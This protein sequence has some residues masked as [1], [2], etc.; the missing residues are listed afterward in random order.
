MEATKKFVLVPE[1]IWKRTKP[2]TT[3]HKEKDKPYKPIKPS[4]PTRHKINKQLNK[5]DASGNKTLTSTIVNYQ[6]EEATQPIKKDS[7]SILDTLKSEKLINFNK[8]NR[9][10]DS[11]GVTYSSV[12]KDYFCNFLD[13]Q[14]LFEYKKLGR[15]SSK[16]KNQL[17]AALVKSSI[18]PEDIPNLSVR[19]TV[20]S[21]RD[22][23]SVKTKWQSS[24]L[25]TVKRQTRQKSP[26]EPVWLAM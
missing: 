1:S 15:G 17:V 19:D 6:I 5:R 10:I 22:K 12:S 13:S 25:Q 4:L 26:S 18:P 8:N 11:K 9:F 14:Q 24:A 20:V 2:A 21:E 23:I 16:S 7:E 3:Q